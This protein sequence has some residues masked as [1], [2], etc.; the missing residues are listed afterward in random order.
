MVW[1]ASEFLQTDKCAA[2]RGRKSQAESNSAVFA[3][4]AKRSAAI[5]AVPGNFLNRRTGKLSWLE[6]GLFMQALSK[7]QP[8]LKS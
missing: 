8:P 4:G 1:I 7:I 3:N 6:V 5:S 2:Q